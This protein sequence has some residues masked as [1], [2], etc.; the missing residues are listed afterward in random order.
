MTMT[1]LFYLM[2][3]PSYAYQAII[4]YT[5]TKIPFM[6]SFSGNCAALVPFPIAHDTWMWKLG[7][8]Q[9]N[10]FSGNICFKFSVLFLCSVHSVTVPST[11]PQG[12]CSCGKPSTQG[13]APA[14]DR[15]RTIWP[16][17][18]LQ[19][20]EDQGPH[21][22]QATGTGTGTTSTS[23][24]VSYSARRQRDNFSASFM[25]SSKISIIVEGDILQSKSGG[26]GATTHFWNKM[27]KWRLFWL[28]THDRLSHSVYF[29]CSLFKKWG[30]WM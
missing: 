12:F 17:G 13:S 10:F 5:A 28:P 4:I 22:S 29:N 3:M 1:P 19:A 2:T 18:A 15:T 27:K 8:W 7:L 14:H 6:Y 23:S 20:A 9:R 11:V 24:Y 21:S 16:P 26:G 25:Y 30:F